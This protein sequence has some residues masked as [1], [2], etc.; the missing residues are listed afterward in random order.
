MA[1]TVFSL[2]IMLCAI[3]A[4]VLQQW[5]NIRIAVAIIVISYLL[6]GVWDIVAAFFAG[7]KSYLQ[8]QYLHSLQIKLMIL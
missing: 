1:A 7:L 4:L 2:V 8:E 5:N 3:I 6:M